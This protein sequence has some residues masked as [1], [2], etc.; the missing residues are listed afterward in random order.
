MG[1]T[2]GRDPAVTAARKSVSAKD[3]APSLALRTLCRHGETRYQRS[4]PAPE[5]PALAGPRVSALTM[6][7]PAV[8]ARFGGS[9]LAAARIRR[10]KV[11]GGLKHEYERAA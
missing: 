7:T 1:G 3:Q 2:G 8:L 10:R 4:S 11:L 6:F 9:D 5:I